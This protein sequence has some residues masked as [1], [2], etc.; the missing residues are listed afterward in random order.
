MASSENP[1][2]SSALSRLTSI[3]RGKV[4]SA[5]RKEIHE[6]KDSNAVAF[7]ATVKSTPERLEPLTQEQTD[8]FSSNALIVEQFIKDFGSQEA[9]TGWTLEDL[10]ASF[11]G[12]LE[13]DDKQGCSGAATTEILGA[14][15]A[16]Y[17]IER[18]DMEWIRV[19]DSDGE[20]FAVLSKACQVR[21]YPFDMISKRIEAGEHGFFAAVFLT[22][23]NS[24]VSGTYATRDA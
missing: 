12:W 14:A 1:T 7:I 24:I 8:R 21:A 15:F 18:L 16:F 20:S 10:D 6:G 19:V 22:L 3:V 11:Q 13:T 23:K 5:F 2:E 17:C 9:S 4:V